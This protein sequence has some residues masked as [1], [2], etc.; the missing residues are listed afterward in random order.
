MPAAPAAA[1]SPKPDGGLARSQSA[2]AVAAPAP[3]ALDKLKRS[4]A[5]DDK[6]KE[7]D[8]NKWSKAEID[9]LDEGKWETPEGASSFIWKKD[10]GRCLRHSFFKGWIKCGH[11]TKWLAASNV[12]LFTVTSIFNFPSLQSSISL[13]FLGM[14]R[15]L[16]CSL[17]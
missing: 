12:R 6:K 11:C 3:S 14:R 1:D 9:E 8:P 16:P 4:R 13:R 2:R 15:P 10:Q 5:S 17:I 7:K